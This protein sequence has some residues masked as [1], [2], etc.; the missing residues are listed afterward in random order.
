MDGFREE[1]KKGAKGWGGWGSEGDM[2][3]TTP[4]FSAFGPLLFG[5]RA[6]RKAPELPEDLGELQSV[7]GRH[8][9]KELLKATERGTNSRSRLFNL[10]ATFWAFLFQIL[11]PT[12]AC[13]EVVRK[14]QAWWG[15]GR[16]KRA[17]AMSTSSAAYCQARARLPLATLQKLFASL[18]ATL[19]QRV[20]A[21]ERWLG[22]RCVKIVDGTGFSM[23]DTAKNQGRWPQMSGQKPGCGFPLIRLVGL[24]CLSSGAL[25]RYAFGSKHDHENHLA[26][27]MLDGVE[28]GDVLLADR[29]FCSYGFFAVLLGLGA[30]AVMR[31]H[32]ARDQSL[33]RGKRLGPN[34]RLMTWTRPRDRRTNDPWLAER[35]HLPETLTV[36]LVRYQVEVRGFR[37]Q[38]ITLATT[39]LDP[40][41]YPAEVLADLYRARW[42]IELRFRE[43]KTTLGADVLRCKSPAMIEKELCLNAIGYNL[44]RCVMQAAAQRH[45]VELGRLSF[46]GS[47]DTVRHFADTIHAVS[48]QPRRQRELY[49]QLLAAI[50]NDELP[51]RP[52][53]NEPRARKRRPKPYQLL[54]KP[55]RQMRVIPHR[56]NYRAAHL[57]G[58]S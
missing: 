56:N 44:I 27:Q 6:H 12:C 45:H 34:Q 30:D 24:F 55:R 52:D 41:E 13:R 38:Q 50:A 7:L 26:R 51:W 53:R 1:S 16:K 22:E 20:L 19:Q 42:G 3:C 4:F 57:G 33:R 25:L 9:P 46:K 17:V 15:R 47:L 40:E 37:T 43:I 29:G 8:M 54:T 14:L 39:L 28:K 49:D 32:Q 18:A 48:G 36:R 11:T 5:R 35:A 10:E 31:L 23:P 21:A 2:R 58:L